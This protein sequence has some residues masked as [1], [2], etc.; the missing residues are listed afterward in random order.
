MSI[1]QALPANINA[2]HDYISFT[3]AP[4]LL[5]AYR[6]FASRSK[7]SLPDYLE[8]AKPLDWHEMSLEDIP[9]D[10]HTKALKDL[11]PI[12]NFIPAFKEINPHLCD[13]SA[14]AGLSLVEYAKEVEKP[15]LKE[16]GKIDISRLDDLCYH[17]LTTFLSSISINL[18]QDA[19]TEDMATEEAWNEV[20]D[21]RQRP[22]GMLGYR[23][24]FDLW[25]NGYH[26]GVAASGAKNGGCY[27]SLSGVGCSLLDFNKVFEVLRVLPAIRLT[28]LDIAVDF[29]EGE[30]SVDD[31]KQLYID[32]GF[33]WNNISP[34]Y[35]LHEGGELKDGILMPIEGRTV[36]IG[37]RVNGKMFRAYEKG[38][39]MGDPDSKWVRGEVELRSKDREIPLYALQRPADYWAGAY[40]CLANIINSENVKEVTRIKTRQKKVEISYNNLLH[41]AKT[42]YGAL[43]NVMRHSAEMTDKEIVDT[44]I[45]PDSVPRRID[46]ANEVTPYERP[47]LPEH[48][49][50]FCGVYGQMLEE[51]QTKYST[52]F[53]VLKN[54]RE[55][56]EQQIFNLITEPQIGA[57][58]CNHQYQ[59]H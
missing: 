15:H 5:A 46:V 29:M 35:H 27:M 57:Q 37:K 21:V 55:L 9:F 6:R 11:N 58:S 34:R 41:H 48:E 54:S 44:L 45:K 14:A 10:C 25:F 49:T 19:H 47:E 7:M 43:I 1:H 4:N 24:S 13:S 38:R 56:T 28:R 59:Q 40:P 39:Q 18:F 51:V 20:F 17:E 52:L 36:N 12:A 31:F 30:Y 53:R 8:E 23:H 50:I 32:G 22:N 26:I 42:S 16:N 33:A 3:W 2:I